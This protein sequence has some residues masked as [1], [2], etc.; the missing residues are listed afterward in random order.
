MLN[1]GRMTDIAHNPTER[2]AFNVAVK[3]VESGVVSK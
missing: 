1:A 3:R 2:S